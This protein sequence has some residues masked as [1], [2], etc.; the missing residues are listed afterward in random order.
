M[1]PPK[2]TGMDLVIAT[3]LPFVIYYGNFLDLGQNRDVFPRQQFHL[4]FDGTIGVFLFSN[5]VST[6]MAISKRSGLEA[7]QIYLAKRGLFFILIGIALSFIWPSNLFMLLGGCAILS[8]LVIPLNSTFLFFLGAIVSLG[9][10]SLS[11]FGDLLIYLSPWTG[12]SPMSLVNHFLKNGHYALLP[13]FL[14]WIV[15]LIYS[16]GDFFTKKGKDL[17]SFMG[18][19]L[20]IIGGFIEFF[21]EYVLSGGTSASN[22]P[23]NRSSILDL[24]L[25]SF[26][27]AASG[28]IIIVFNL[29]MKFNERV[30]SGTLITALRFFGKMKYSVL[31]AQAIVGGMISFRLTGLETYG[32][33]S[34]IAMTVSGTILSIIVS[35]FWTKRFGLGPVEKVLKMFN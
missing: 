12:N 28:L 34:I 21:F 30:E 11:H 16:R 22:H 3:F 4:I 15:G 1:R 31:L 2:I 20:L 33:A 25:P 8:A 10:I 6:G 5:A 9:A 14:F 35:Y 19:I 18:V 13:W 7:L 26:L 32:C 23:F 17:R 24:H 29:I 27:V